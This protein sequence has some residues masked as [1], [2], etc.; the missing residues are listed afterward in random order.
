MNRSLGRFKLPQ[1][2]DIQ[3][4]NEWLPIISIATNPDNKMEF[5]KNIATNTKKNVAVDS[6]RNIRKKIFFPNMEYISEVSGY[7]SF[8]DFI[9][10]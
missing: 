4:E 10:S 3:E 8:F 7:F 1:P 5:K 6:N 2:V 9:F